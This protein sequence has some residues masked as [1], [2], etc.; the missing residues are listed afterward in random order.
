MRLCEYHSAEYIAKFRRSYSPVREESALSIICFALCTLIKYTLKNG[1]RTHPKQVG[2]VK[3]TRTTMI[4][5]APR[6]SPNVVHAIVEEVVVQL[7]DGL[8]RVVVDR[9]GRAV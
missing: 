7:E 5:Y 9:T 6:K 1:P 8:L 2:C 4:T 3:L